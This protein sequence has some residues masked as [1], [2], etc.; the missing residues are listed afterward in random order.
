MSISSRILALSLASVACLAGPSTAGAQVTLANDTFTSASPTPSPSAGNNS[1]IGSPGTYTSISNTTLSVRDDTGGINSGNALFSS[2]TGTFSK[3]FTN[4]GEITLTA[5][6]PT[7]RLSFD[8][9]YDAQPVGNAGAQ[10]RF[11]F[12]NQNGTSVN[13]N[14]DPGYHVQTNPGANFSTGSAFFSE[15]GT[16]ESTL[17]GADTQQIG[18]GFGSINFGISPVRVTFSISLTDTGLNFNATI[19]SV[20]SPTVFLSNTD[21]RFTSIGTTFDSFVIGE[22][23][24]TTNTA[25]LLDNVNIVLVP[26]PS[27][28]ALLLGGAACLVAMQLRRRRGRP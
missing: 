11:G 3:L 25:F 16:A 19:G 20:V 2:N 28:W 1:V 27:T 17:G 23:G 15:L 12:Y 8:L 21:S 18:S 9:R 26:E 7:I 5:N 10:L 22:G 6:N 24:S 14:N 4:F 13:D